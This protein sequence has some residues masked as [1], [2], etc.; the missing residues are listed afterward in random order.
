M[1]SLVRISLWPSAPACRSGVLAAC[2][3]WK[4]YASAP[5]RWDEMTDQCFSDRIQ[6]E[7]KPV[8]RV[9]GFVEWLVPAS[10]DGRKHQRAL[11]RISALP[12]PLFNAEADGLRN[13]NQ[14]IVGSTK[15]VLAF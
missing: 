2:H 6:S 3:G 4:S 15:A 14:A 12:A 11:L 1:L 9:H 10:P 5:E 7:S 13:G 8:I